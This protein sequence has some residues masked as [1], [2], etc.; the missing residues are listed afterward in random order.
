MLSSTSR[1]FL[2]RCEVQSVE[3]NDAQDQPSQLRRLQLV[4]TTRFSPK[5][6]L[7]VVPTL[8]APRLQQMRFIQRGDG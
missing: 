3:E 2:V 7:A 5:P 8:P 1:A 6:I 4:L